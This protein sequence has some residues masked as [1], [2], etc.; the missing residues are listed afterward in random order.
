VPLI[1]FVCFESVSATTV[2][3]ADVLSGQVLGVSSEATV[4]AV[5]KA[6]V[7][8]GA[9]PRPRP[10]VSPLPRPRLPLPSKN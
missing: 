3:S 10:R 9:A 8:P 2:S 7:D 6:S 5:E 1:P 4:A